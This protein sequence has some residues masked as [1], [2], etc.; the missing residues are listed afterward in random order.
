MCR[1]DCCHN[2]ENSKTDNGQFSIASFRILDNEIQWI[3]RSFV[4]CFLCLL[5]AC[6]GS[7]SNKKLNSSIVAD[8]VFFGGDILTM[9]GDS[10]HYVEALALKDGKIIALGLKKD[11]DTLIAEST[12]Q[13]DLKGRTLLPG[14]ID[15]HSHLTKYADGLLQADLNAPP[16]GKVESIADIISALK[17]LKNDR[18]LS[19]TAWIIGAGYDHEMLKENRHPTAADLDKEFPNNPVLLIHA[20]NHMLVANSAAFRK[21]GVDANTKDTDGG[22][23]IRKKGSREPEGLV[24]EMAQYAFY[25]FLVGDFSDEEEFDKLK[26]A[27]DYYASQGLTTVSEHMA[28]PEKQMVL[29]KAAANKILFLDVEMLPSHTYAAALIDSGNVKWGVMENHLKFAGVKMVTDG[30]PQGKTAFLTSPYLTPVP[31]CTHDCR[32]FSNMSQEQIND[33]MVL[34]YSNKVQVYSHC[35]GDA[36]IDMMIEGHRF[37]NAQLKDSTSDRRTVVIHSQVV[38]PDQLDAYKRYQMIPS[39]FSNHCY[40]WGDAHLANLGEERAGFI[41]PLN[42][43]QKKGI[44]YTNHT[45]CP[46]TPMD[47]MFLLWTSVARETRKGAVIGQAEAVTPFQGLKAL[48]I[49]AAYQFFEEDIKGSLKVG[50]MADLVVLDRNPVK[51]K[52]GEIPHI[53]VQETIKEGKT[54]FLRKE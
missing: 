32:G 31:G 24:Q 43:S 15:A 1:G 25:E 23:F 22:T 54:V 44:V 36:S 6:S 46:V 26:K 2:N 37:A 19:D 51:V 30:S 14:F 50:K 18:Q 21:A 41:S 4:L 5:A 3:M 10:P 8:R 39:F 16:V 12:Q 11:I 53:K 27:Q 47:Q 49:H 20:S 28:V 38:R 48:T 29:E 9:E 35:N 17:A 45:D 13:T 34:C 40:Y 52:T 33:L 42:S 7:D